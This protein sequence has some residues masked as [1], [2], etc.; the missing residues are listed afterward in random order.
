MRFWALAACAVLAACQQPA[1]QAL[2]VEGAW[3]RLPAA[4]GRPAAAYF[5]VKGGKTAEQ[6][7]SIDSPLAIRAELHDMKMAGGV[8]RMTPIEGGVAVPAGGSV[9]FAPGG[10]HAMLFDISP[11]ASTSRPFPLT[12]RFA[13]G[14][15]LETE[16]K[17]QAPGDAAPA[18]DNAH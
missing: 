4:S 1:E 17:A 5:T 10:R 6:L 12:L 8:M 2:S 9:A 11:D 18:Q 15:T 16:A 14:A 7:L 3:V 13:S